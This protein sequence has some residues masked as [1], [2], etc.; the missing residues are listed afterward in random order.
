VRPFWRI[1]WHRDRGARLRETGGRWWKFDS[2]FIVAI[3]PGTS[4]EHDLRV[5]IRAFY[6]HG[7]AGQPFDRYRGPLLRVSIGAET[8]N[9]LET[10]CAKFESK[11]GDARLDAG[12]RI[13]M[14]AL[15]LRVLSEIPDKDWP[16][17]PPDR[18]IREALARIETAA[19]TGRKLTN[20]Q[21]A[22]SSGMS[23]NA[24]I[25]LFGEEIGESP[26]D[27]HSGRSLE[28]ACG[29]LQDREQTIEAVAE[30]CGFCDRFHFTRMFRRRFGAGPATW[31]REVLDSPAAGA[32]H[33]GT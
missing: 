25:R 33:S 11:D 23:V 12:T 32:W 26:Q 15:F 18:R 20:P 22:R 17:P 10:I 30:A 16:E 4:V 31:R 14:R 6:I 21:L 1:S 19:A 3:P 13:R 8:R 28:R 9:L 27:Y 5:G 29:L 7:F 24:F 2:D